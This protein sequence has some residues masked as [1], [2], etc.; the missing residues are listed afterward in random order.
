MHFADLGLVEPIVRAVTAEGYTTATDIQAGAIPPAM[1]GRDILGTAQTGTGKT[2]A[3][4][5]PILHRLA[6]SDSGLE[7]KAAR[8][9]RNRGQRRTVSPRALILCPTRELATQIH[10]RF[11]SYGRQLKL[12]YGVVYGGVNQYHQVRALRRG[13]DVLVAT[14]GRLKD[15]QEQGIINLSQVETLVLD[16][17][18]RMLDMGFVHDIRRIVAL[19]PDQ[20]QT[21]LFSATISG[22][23]RTLADDLMRDPELVETAPESTTLD[24]IEQRLFMVEPHRKVQLLTHV[25]AEDRVQRAL[26]FTRT[27]YGADKVAKRLAR[28]G[29]GADAIHANKTQAARNT[30]MKD[31]KSGRIRVLVATDIASR[32]LDVDDVTHVVNYDMPVDPET[33]VHRIGR[34]ARAGATGTAVTFCCPDQAKLLRA[35]E[36]RTQVILPDAEELP[37]M[38][39]PPRVDQPEAAP[40]QATPRANDQHRSSRQTAPERR[41]GHKGKAG[42]FKPKREGGFKP[43]WQRDGEGRDGGERR[44]GYKGKAG[45]FKPKREGGFKPKWQR[46]GEGRDGGERRGGYKGK[47]GS[48]KPKREGGFKPKW[49]RDGEGRDGGERRGGYKGKPGGFKPKWQRD[50]EGR[51]GGERRGG[52]KGKPGGFKPKRE[53]GIKPKWQRDGEGRDGGERRGGYKGKAGDHKKAGGFKPKRE[54]GFKPKWKRDGE[55]RTARSDSDTRSGTKGKSGGYR[56]KPNGSKP[57]QQGGAKPKRDGGRRVSNSSRRGTSKRLGIG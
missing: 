27:K 4:A 23:I 29:V 45:S 24:T 3:F 26:V 19:M 18:D 25:L 52:Y 13:A 9:D 12:G 53:G 7:G 11:V 31:F 20:R 30:T 2:C 21:L 37:A 14:P 55:S 47:A 41:G 43:K 34:T 22:T 1:A 40:A 32:G 6:E 8:F 42:G 44:G 54:G 39:T 33:W 36:R 16:E 38:T 17:A 51:D 50:G 15:L 35:I 28:S 5:L 10:E 46:D 48:F 56:G 57:V 49:Q